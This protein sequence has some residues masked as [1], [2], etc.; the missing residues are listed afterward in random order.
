MNI[1]PEGEYDFVDVR[2]VVDGLIA[3]AKLGKNGEGYFLSGQK[4]TITKFM[5]IISQYS[6]SKVPKVMSPIWLSKFVSHLAKVYYFFLKK[7]LY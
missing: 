5:E 1:R 3:A 7:I 2:D 4:M 6:A